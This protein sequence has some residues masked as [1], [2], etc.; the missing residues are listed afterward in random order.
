MKIAVI[1]ISGMVKMN[2]KI[3][4]TLY[5]MRLRRKYACVVLEDTKENLGMIKKVDNFV[6]YGEIDEATYKELVEKRGKKDKDNKLKPFFRLH[7]AR[8]GMET[9]KHFGV[10]KGVL[11]NQGK[12]INKLIKRML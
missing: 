6:A 11:G 10:D 7:P 4:D 2:E 9:K 1:R 8:G 5:R 12:E 3:E